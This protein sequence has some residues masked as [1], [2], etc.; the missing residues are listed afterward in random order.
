MKI[1]AAFENELEIFGSSN[2]M[3]ILAVTGIP[4]LG[5][6]T[7]IKSFCKE[8]FDE[9]LYFSPSSSSLS[10]NTFF[11]TPNIRI[12]AES[13]YDKT[14]VCRILTSDDNKSIAVIFDD[15]QDIISDDGMKN[16]TVLIKSLLE[17]KIRLTHS[18]YSWEQKQI[19][20]ILISNT[21]DRSNLMRFYNSGFVMTAD[22]RRR[23]DMSLKFE[24]HAD[25]YMDIIKAEIKRLDPIRS[26]EIITAVNWDLLTGIVNDIYNR[27]ADQV[28]FPLCITPR[29]FVNYIITVYNAKISEEKQLELIKSILVIN[30]NTGRLQEEDILILLCKNSKL[31]IFHLFKK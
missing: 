3:Q 10:P 26:D 16:L 31:N 18:E 21:F 27:F 7:L 14:D 2:C 8:H 11:A 6:S 13:K 22:L 4:G 9:T 23:I 15:I 29:H 25:R 1:I 12:T 17:G 28:D 5:K 20:L 19:K 24:Y 30:R